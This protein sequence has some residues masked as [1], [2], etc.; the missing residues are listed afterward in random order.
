MALPKDMQRGKLYKAEDAAFEGCSFADDHMTKLQD[1]Q[2][3]V[4]Q[5]TSS[6]WWRREVGRHCTIVVTHGGGRKFAEACSITREI[7]L[8]TK[9]RRAYVVLH[10]LSHIAANILNKDEC[11]HD[12]RFTAMYLKMVRHWFG[13]EYADKL[14]DEFKNH[15]VRYRPAV[16]NRMT[17]EQRAVAVAR[18]KRHSK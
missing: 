8:P 16:V 10:E 7:R 17:P 9:M 6:N 15:G 11:Q 12:R 1:I 4:D 5:I 14:R 13:R 2:D 3:W 18:L